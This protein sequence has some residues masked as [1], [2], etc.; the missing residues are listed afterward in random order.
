MENA[1]AFP[2]RSDSTGA[3]AKGFSV[4]F[5]LPPELVELDGQLGNDLFTLNGCCYRMLRVHAT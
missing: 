2:R 1:R 5:E 3:A 4:A